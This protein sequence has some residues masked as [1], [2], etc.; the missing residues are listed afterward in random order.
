MAWPGPSCRRR[1][2]ARASTTRRRLSCP[3][4]ATLLARRGLVTWRWRL[5][6]H[7]WRRAPTSTPWPPGYRRTSICN[8]PS[9]QPPPRSGEGEED[10][11]LP[12]PASGRGL[13]GGVVE[14]VAQAVEVAGV[15][16]LEAEA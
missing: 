5:D 13:G 7:A 8:S 11:L 6:W 12:L 10:C 16:L 14:S 9:P 3:Y 1:A 4:C 15:D 2:L